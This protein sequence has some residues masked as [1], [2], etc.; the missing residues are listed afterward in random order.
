MDSPGFIQLKT[1]FIHR[2]YAAYSDSRGWEVGCIENLQRE[3]KYGACG[4][5]EGQGHA[6]CQSSSDSTR[7]IPAAPR[8]TLILQQR[9]KRCRAP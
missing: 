1:Y 2:P 6:A 4:G 7:S 9:S 3:D 5:V 8:A